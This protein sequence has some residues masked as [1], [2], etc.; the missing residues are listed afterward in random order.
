MA[1]TV[2]LCVDD[3]TSLL[4]ALRGLLAQ[5]LGPK[6]WVEI[7][8]SAEEALEISR[9]LA[10]QG[11]HLAVVISDYIMPGM[12]G[13]E[14]LV[15]L[16]GMAPAAV[17]MMLT[18]QSDLAAVKRALAEAELYRFIEKPFASEDLVHCTRAALRTYWERVAL[19]SRSGAMADARSGLCTTAALAELLDERLA[20]PA[21]QPLCV[22]LIEPAEA[23]APDARPVLALVQQLQS[24]QRRSDV[25]GRWG[26]EAFLIINCDQ[27]LEEARAHAEALRQRLALQGVQGIGQLS[28]GVACSRPGERAAQLIDRAHA[29]LE[30]ARAAGGL[31]VGVAD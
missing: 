1:E 7:A 23:V 27:E 22:T 4:Q 13:D 31:R 8:E 9:D 5:H 15:R 14:L 12:R 17:K 26:G 11:H 30:A 3:D 19:L 6:H 18:G 10:E 21:A 16:H 2:I 20:S 28:L 25:V 24:H 29:A